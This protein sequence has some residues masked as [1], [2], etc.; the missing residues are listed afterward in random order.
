L[1]LVVNAAFRA[2]GPKVRAFEAA[3]LAIFEENAAKVG[4]NQQIAEQRNK[5]RNLPN[6]SAP[7]RSSSRA[8]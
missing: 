6:Q 2:S 5:P 8:T 7:H 1:S 4:K 3:M